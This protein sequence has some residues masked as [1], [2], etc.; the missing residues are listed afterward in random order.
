MKVY[1]S[2]ENDAGEVIARFTAPTVDMAI[3]KMG[4]WELKAQEPIDTER[5]CQFC[6]LTNE[7]N[8]G[9]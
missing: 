6:D 4:A 7:H 1:C 9:N 5:V 3:E 2:I 8:H